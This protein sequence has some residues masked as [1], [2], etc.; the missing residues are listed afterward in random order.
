[1]RILIIDSV[2]ILA[3]VYQAFGKVIRPHLLNDSVDV[4]QYRYREVKL[5]Y[6]QTDADDTKQ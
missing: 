2:K 5:N 4:Y 3:S 6:N 1:M